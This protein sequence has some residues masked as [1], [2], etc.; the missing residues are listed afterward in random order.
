MTATTTTATTATTTTTTTAGACDRRRSAE[1]AAAQQQLTLERRDGV[2]V[3]TLTGTPHRANV[4]TSALVVRLDQL[5]STVEAAVAAAVPAVS[6]LPASTVSSSRS[7]PTRSAPTTGGGGVASLVVVGTGTFFS[8]GFDLAS[9]TSASEGPALVRQTWKVLARLLVLPVPTVCLYN[10]H[11]FGLGLFLGLA[12]DHRLMVDN[13]DNGGNARLCLPEIHIGLPLG[14]G[15]A[16]LAKCKLTAVALT[17]AALTG[18]RFTATEALR[19]G[20]VDDVVAV[21]AQPPANAALAAAVAL[22]KSL[23]QT[24]SRGNLRSIKMELYGDAHAVLLHPPRSSL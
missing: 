7:A 21:V 18:A 8:A 4:F 3:L 14:P 16:A 15:F 1:H 10:G 5:L 9:I 6:T 22:A 24:S 23:E 12:C 13:N 11:A 2:F 19:Y 17:Q 20:L